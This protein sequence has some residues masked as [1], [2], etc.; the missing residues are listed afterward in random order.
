MFYTD[1][2][3]Y[4]IMQVPVSV[5]CW[6]PKAS[7]SIAQGTALGLDRRQK[8]S[9]PVRAKLSPALVSPLQGSRESAPLGLQLHALSPT[10]RAY[11][12]GYLRSPRCGCMRAA[13]DP[14]L[15]LA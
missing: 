7:K 13:G 14:M 2:T 8:P 12:L 3:R 6:T 11:A 10:P 4:S 5:I 9:S 1:P 15:S